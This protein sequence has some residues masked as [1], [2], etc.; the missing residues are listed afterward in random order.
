MF[1]SII[2]HSYFFLKEISL[3]QKDRQQIQTQNSKLNERIESF[4]P[5]QNSAD[6]A[7]IL[8]NQTKHLS[9]EAKEGKEK[10]KDDQENTPKQKEKSMID[11][12]NKSIASIGDP[13]YQHSLSPTCKVKLR[14]EIFIHLKQ[15]SID[16]SYTIGD[17]LGEGQVNIVYV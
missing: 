12:N 5:S 17:L 4:T 7:K 6:K 16:S 10:Q 15:G 1:F 8:R 13:D 3:F 2:Y 14:A 9:F 11:L